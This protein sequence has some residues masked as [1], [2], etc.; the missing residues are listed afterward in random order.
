MPLLHLFILA[1]VQGVTEFLPISS[2]A[3]LILVPRLLGVA[4]QGLVLDVAVH[5][6]TLLAVI[7]YLRREIVAMITSLVT[8]PPPGVETKITGNRQ[9]AFMIV[10]ASIPVALA[11]LWMRSTGIDL[12]LRDMLV[13]GW[14][15]IGFGIVLWLADRSGDLG[16]RLSDMKL[17]QAV[18]IGLAQVLA[19]IPGTSRAGITITAA[20]MYG[21]GREDSTRFSMLLAIPVIILAGLLGAYEIY[22][23]QDLVLG[24][25][26]LVAM[27]LSFV[28]A[29][30]TIAGFIRLTRRFSMLPFVVYRVL[31]GIVLLAVGYQ[32]FPL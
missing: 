27:L 2:S 12:L 21:F 9:L 24:T 28:T 13:I 1:L 30:V 19:L 6:G 15:S 26:A 17:R 14:A 16:N 11:G 23:S 20:R 32:W 22:R 5:V 18:I 4:D 10:Y 8:T 3:H 25:D 29:Y 7:L 31:L